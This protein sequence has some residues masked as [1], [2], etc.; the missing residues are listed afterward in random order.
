[1]YCMYTCIFTLRLILYY[2]C[3]YIYI[4]IYISLDIVLYV[5]VNVVKLPYKWSRNID[6]T[7]D[8]LILPKR[9]LVQFA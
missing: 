3:I 8:P 7:F 6:L 4:Y 9:P 1:M 2:M 5:Y